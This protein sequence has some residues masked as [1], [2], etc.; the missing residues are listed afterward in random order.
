M[1][2]RCLKIAIMGQESG[3]KEGLQQSK[4][5]LLVSCFRY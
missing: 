4:Q 5:A 2:R 3:R 1:L